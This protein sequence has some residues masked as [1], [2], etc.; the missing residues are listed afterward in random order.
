M[1]SFHLF[2]RL[3]L[4]LRRQTWDLAIPPRKLHIGRQEMYLDNPDP[5][6]P[7]Y[8]DELDESGDPTIRDPDLICFSSREV[9]SDSWSAFA[10]AFNKTPPALQTCH[11]FRTYH[12]SAGY[13]KAFTGGLN[14]I[15]TWVNFNVDIIIT[16]DHGFRTF[17]EEAQRIVHLSASEIFHRYVPDPSWPNYASIVGGFRSASLKTLVLFDSSNMAYEPMENMIPL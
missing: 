15:Y 1:A 10:G 5:D 14:P 8:S 4:E 6:E 11:E 13:V 3:P 9:K 12:Q 17:K 7:P 16:S 2:P